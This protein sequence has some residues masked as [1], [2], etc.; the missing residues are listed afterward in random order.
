MKTSKVLV[1]VA[2]F[3][4]AGAATTFAMAAAQ[5]SSVSPE[6]FER[7]APFSIVSPT[8]MPKWTENTVV[9]V[10][11][12]VDANG[13]PRDIAMVD[14]TPKEV[15]ARIIPAVAHWRFTPM[16]V[17]GHTVSARI[18]VPVRLVAGELKG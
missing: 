11:L 1:S 3:S 6:R 12:T 2:L 5:D 7:P 15:S 14:R 4:L 10:A 8:E 16:S 9:K 17:N 13:V 18:V